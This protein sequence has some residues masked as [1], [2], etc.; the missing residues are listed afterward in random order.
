MSDK[1]QLLDEVDEIVTS[2][3]GLN[4]GFFITIL[5]LIVFTIMLLFPKIYLAQQIYYKSRDIAKLEAEYN[6]LQEEHKRIKSSV[7]KIKFKNQILDTIF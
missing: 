3:Y 6:T 1:N 7:E 2:Q 4:G 5:L